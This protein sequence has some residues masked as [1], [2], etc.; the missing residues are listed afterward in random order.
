MAM[1]Q[2]YREAVVLSYIYFI[3]SIVSIL[4]LLSAFIIFTYFRY[5]YAV[6]ISANKVLCCLGLFVAWTVCPS[7][8]LVEKL[9][10]NFRWILWKSKPWNKNYN[11]LDFSS[12]LDDTDPDFLLYWTL[13]SMGHWYKAIIKGTALWLVSSGTDL[14]SLSVSRCRSRCRS[15]PT[16]CSKSHSDQQSALQTFCDLNTQTGNFPLINIATDSYSIVIR[17]LMQLLCRLPLVD[18]NLCSV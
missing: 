5:A 12:D 1:Q 6:V 11:P 18:I 7:S 9:W 8:L 2:R 10:I 15:K 13:Q 14:L 17:P 4:L 3:G 16:Y